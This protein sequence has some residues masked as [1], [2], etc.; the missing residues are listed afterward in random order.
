MDCP[1]I[2]ILTAGDNN[3]ISDWYKTVDCVW[4]AGELVTVQPILTPVRNMFRKKLI[5]CT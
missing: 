1:D 3:V 2:S 5:K 4:V